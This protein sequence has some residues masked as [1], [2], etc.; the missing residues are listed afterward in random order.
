MRLCKHHD[1]AVPAPGVAFIVA[2]AIAMLYCVFDN[3]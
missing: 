1:A 2:L 3:Q